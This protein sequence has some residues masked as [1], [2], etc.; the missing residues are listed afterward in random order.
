MLHSFI[1][2]NL[3]YRFYLSGHL[4]KRN[5]FLKQLVVPRALIN[6][7]LHARH[8]HTRSGELFTFKFIFEKIWD[9]YWWPTLSRNAQAWCLGCQGCRRHK[10]SHNRHWL[11]IG[12]TPMKYPFQYVFVDLVE[13]QTTSVFHDNLRCKFVVTLIDY[14]TRFAVLCPPPDIE[15]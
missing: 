13:Y 1:Y 3:L 2:D 8:H 9:P 11:L 6:F 7:V 15:M 10:K 4:M 5:T 12:R 14:L